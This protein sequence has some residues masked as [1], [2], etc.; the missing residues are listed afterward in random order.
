MD[1]SPTP[2][3]NR[4]IEIIAQ[5]GALRLDHFMD[6]AL[7]DPQD[8]YYTTHMPIGAPY[9]EGG[10]F[11]TA[12]EVSQIFGELIGAWCLD[13]WQKN[14][15]DEPVQLIELGPGRGTL[16]ADLWRVI[17]HHH[18]SDHMQLHCVETSPRLRAIQAEKVPHAQWHDHIGAVPATAPCIIIANEFFDALPT[19]QFRRT[20]DGWSERYVSCEKNTLV[21]VDCPFDGPSRSV[22]KGAQEQD[23]DM[24]AELRRLEDQFALGQ[25]VELSPAA[26][27][28]S[29]HIAARLRQTGGALLAIDYGYGKA[30]DRDNSAAQ[31]GGEDL[32]LPFSGDSLQAMFRHQFVSP[33]SHIG[34]ADLTTHVNFDA[35]A[36]SLK[37]GQITPLPLLTQGTFLNALGIHARTQKL[38]ASHPDHAATLFSGTQRLTAAD[39]MGQLFK[40]L[41]AISSD[42]PVPLP[43]SEK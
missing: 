34:A 13:L 11:I 10:D 6:L 18:F 41:C 17:D 30:A 7:F 16:S 28:Y 21:F 8:G 27:L 3:E 38:A 42:F 43:F 32:S 29:D 2:L 36:Q 1:L 15:R 22:E 4:L 35:L 24:M 19:R 25:C 31:A 23:V 40:V 9:A 37:H 26:R 20:A 14:G 33:L 5:N 39:E 12:P